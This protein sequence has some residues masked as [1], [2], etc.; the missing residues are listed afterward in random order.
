MLS[1][2]DG[3]PVQ[4]G[5]AVTLEDGRTQDVVELVVLT[6]A[7]KAETGV[8]EHGVMLLSPLFGRA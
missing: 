6:A 4:V 3:S 1:Y 7:Q 5:D 8:E 2:A